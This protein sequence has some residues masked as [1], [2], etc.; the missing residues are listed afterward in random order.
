[1]F[2]QGRKEERVEK[3]KD[4]SIDIHKYRER[5]GAKNTIPDPAHPIYQ[6]RQT[7]KDHTMFD[8]L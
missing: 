2:L 1:M 5:V 3:W 7:T 8:L 6:E 4:T